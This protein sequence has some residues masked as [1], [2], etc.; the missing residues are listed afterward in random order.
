MTLHLSFYIPCL[1]SILVFSEQMIFALF[2]PLKASSPP[3]C[4][5]SRFPFS[6][7]GPQ[8]FY[9]LVIVGMFFI[10]RGT[11]KPCSAPYVRSTPL[12]SLSTAW[13]TLLS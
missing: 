1:L 8:N 10:F 2:R 5:L 12:I 4:F 11:P 3:T 7:E 9:F 6:Y 13:G